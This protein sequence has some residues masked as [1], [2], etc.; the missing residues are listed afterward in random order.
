MRYALAGS[1]PSVS[2]LLVLTVVAASA[3]AALWSFAAAP[4][5]LALGNVRLP[6]SAAPDVVLAL[7]YLVVFT[8]ALAA[9]FQLGFGYAVGSR[10]VIAGILF[11]AVLMIVLFVVSAVF[12]GP[13]GGT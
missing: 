8:A 7:G 4:L 5:V 11:A 9:G 1:M 13:F 10:L 6:W 2:T 12:F 3:A